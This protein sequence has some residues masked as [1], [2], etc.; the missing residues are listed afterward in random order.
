M[1]AIFLAVAAIV[2]LTAPLAAQTG[3]TVKAALAPALH[4]DQAAAVRT[5][6]GMPNCIRAVELSLTFARTLTLCAR[7]AHDSAALGQCMAKRDQRI[8]EAAIIMCV[9]AFKD[10]N[11]PSLRSCDQ[12]VMARVADA[13]AAQAKR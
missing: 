3:P 9:S 11:L 10:S 6:M 2:A 1:K 5:C 4:A 7:G 8:P 13:L 12:Q